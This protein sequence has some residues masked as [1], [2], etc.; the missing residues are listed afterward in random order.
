MPFD[1]LPSSCLPFSVSLFI[2]ESQDQNERSYRIVKTTSRSADI[3]DLTPLTSYVFHVRA[4][5]AAGYGE[6]SAPF[7]F[8][9]NTSECRVQNDLKS[10]SYILKKYKEYLI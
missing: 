10:A 1:F 8:S 2:Y 5:T 7:E 3:K 9:T 4:R 6:F